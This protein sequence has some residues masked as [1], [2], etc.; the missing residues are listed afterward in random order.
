MWLYITHYTTTNDSHESKVYANPKYS[1]LEN[2]SE[3]CQHNV[4]LTLSSHSCSCFSE[5]PIFW[6]KVDPTSPYQLIPVSELTPEYNTVAGYVKK[7]GLLDRSIV[8][9]RRIQNLDLWEMYCRKKKQLM[10]IQGV[11]EIQERRLFHGTDSKNVDSI[12]KYN[13]DVR[14]AGQHGHSYGKGVYF[15]KHASYADKYSTSSTDPFSLYGGLTGSVFRDTKIIFLA[16]VMVG[17]STL[18]KSHYKKPDDGSSEN[19]HNSCVDNIKHPNMFVIFDPNQIYP[20]YLI[21]YR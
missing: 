18:G 5:A 2:E 8:S 9:I 7:E 6:E 19:S 3:S 15:A 4:N 10:R 11:E 1:F 13:F 12:C 16:R 14:L 21:Q 17:K 20:E